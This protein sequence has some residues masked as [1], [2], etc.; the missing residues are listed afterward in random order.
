[1]SGQQ[2]ITPADA[3]MRLG[4]STAEAIAQVLEMFLPGGVERGDV[5]VLSD[6]ARHPVHVG[7]ARRDRPAG[8][9]REG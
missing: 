7:H 4:A 1:M 6:G 5:T 9:A 2:D 3:L 8:H